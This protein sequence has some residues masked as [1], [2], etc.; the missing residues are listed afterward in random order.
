MSVYTLEELGLE[1]SHKI[2]NGTIM[3]LL[4][5]QKT[6]NT[7]SYATVSRGIIDMDIYRIHKITNID[8]M[9]YSGSVGGGGLDANLR[10]ATNAADIGTINFTGA[11]DNIIKSDNVLS[12]LENITGKIEIHLRIRKAGAVGPSVLRA[13][14][15]QF[16]G[17]LV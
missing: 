8:F 2:V 10:D 4:Q 17:V 9:A 3:S 11:Q 15:I 12:Y 6:T 7:T 5:E 16:Y 14:A 13:A 1:L